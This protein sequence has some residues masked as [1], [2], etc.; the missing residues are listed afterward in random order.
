MKYKNSKF[1]LIGLLV[2]S[3]II[4]ISAINATDD[5]TST[6]MIKQHDDISTINTQTNKDTITQQ[7]NN[8]KSTKKLENKNNKKEAIS[9]SK[10]NTT[11]KATHTVNNYQELYNKIEEIKTSPDNT[12]INLNPGDYTIT[13]QITWG[14]TDQQSKTMTINGN[15]QTIDGENIKQFIIVENG[16][17]LNLQNITIKQCFT[18]AL[19]AGIYNKGNTSIINST[20]T[21]NNESVGGG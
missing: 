3:I 13:T 6:N 20:F 21:E 1:L 18:T 17:T 19:G 9:N 15:G 8:I 7:Q 14:S 4:S 5:N 2:L 16:Y 12:T 11:K 10:E